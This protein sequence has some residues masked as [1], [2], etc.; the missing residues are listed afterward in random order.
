MLKKKIISLLL[1]SMLSLLLIVPQTM[2]NVS[3]VEPDGSSGGVFVENIDGKS[4]MDYP[5]SNEIKQLQQKKSKMAEFHFQYKQGKISK[6]DYI[7]KLMGLGASEDTI[8]AVSKTKI[9]SASPT[10][11]SNVLPLSSTSSQNVLIPFWQIPQ[12]HYYY[13][14]PATASEI[15]KAKT[16]TTYSQDTLAVPLHCNTNGTP[17]YDGVSGSGYPMA[18]T[19]NS[20]INTSFYI[21]YG[22]TVDASQFQSKVVYDIDQNYGTAGD[23]WEVPNGPHLV[24]HP[25]GSEIYHWLAIYGYQ[26]YA[27]DILYKDSVNGCTEISWSGNVPASSSMNY[28]TLARIVNGRGII[29]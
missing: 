1:I 20:Y 19:L 25:V 15:I 28:A 18:D 29:W 11:L 13:C 5:V 17:W 24:G 9:F 27:N 2:A 23:A 10:N 22:T 12:T 3:A 14:G 26:N 8:N 4:I 16:F 21:P 6:E 7:S